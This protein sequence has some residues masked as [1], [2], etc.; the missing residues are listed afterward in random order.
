MTSRVL[1]KA[2]TA[3]LLAFF[4][5]PATALA[6]FDVSFS[7]TDS[8]DP[9][10]AGD[11]LTYTITV[12]NQGTETF[13]PVDVDIYSLEVGGAHGVPNPNLSVTPS[14][15]TCAEGS[16]VTYQEQICTLGP[17]PP[18]ASAEIVNVVHANVSMDHVAGLINPDDDPSD[19]VA[20]ERT[21]VIVPPKVAGSP[22]VKLKG[23]PDGCLAADTQITATAKIGKVK[24]IKAKLIGRNVSERLGRA[25]GNKLG[26]VLDADQLEQARFYELNVNVTRKGKPGI[27]RS[28]EFQRC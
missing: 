23:L 1:T 9:V 13:D 8:P 12:T 7:Q 24:E 4:V 11:R 28:V 16:A 26:F 18:G 15:G 14:Q 2:L 20:Q 19:D 17:L 3:G 25:A 10:L 22:K 5:S 21:T 6:S 27:K